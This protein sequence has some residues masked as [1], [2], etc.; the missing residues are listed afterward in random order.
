MMSPVKELKSV[1]KISDMLVALQKKEEQCT[2]EADEL[3][4][5]EYQ[6]D[7]EFG[8]LVK[9]NKKFI[10]TKLS[11][12]Q[13]CRKVGVPNS[14]FMASSPKLA[15]ELLQEFGAAKKATPA[16][17]L[18]QFALK[19][20]GQKHFLRGILPVEYNSTKNSELLKPF[21]ALESELTVQNAPW[22][23][24]VDAEYVRTRMVFQQTLRDINGD[25]I[26]I[27]LDVGGS[28][29]GAGPMQ[30]AILVY[31]LVCE[32]GA[33]AV[34][35]SKPYF[36]YDY[37]G[38]LAVDMGT[39]MDAVQKRLKDDVPALITVVDKS[40]QEKWSKEKSELAL[41]RMQSRG[42]LNKGVAIKVERLL[43]KE[44]PATRWDFVNHI[45]AMARGY[46]DQLR[47]RYESAAGQE[48]GLSFSRSPQE[49]S[50]LDSSKPKALPAPAP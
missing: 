5:W 44:P 27:A 2:V 11:T 25:K 41:G 28:E 7:S 36:Y 6:R 34:Y 10:L 22:Y 42:A 50:W 43:D 37:K 15:N 20:S 3:T 31:R 24:E 47:L 40:M 14:V 38:V 4:D 46:R 1:G 30:A 45:T 16:G 17:N 18:V 9:G 39:I 29:L 33:I 48:L 19:S 26:Y 35:N 49:P 23:D 8:S 32:N 12:K 13:L 21:Q